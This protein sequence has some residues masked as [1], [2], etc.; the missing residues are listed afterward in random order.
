M[1]TCYILPLSHSIFVTRCFLLA[2]GG[3]LYGRIHYRSGGSITTGPRTSVPGGGDYRTVLVLSPVIRNLVA[4]GPLGY[5]PG[6]HSSLDP[7]LHHEGALDQQTLR[8]H[9]HLPRDYDPASRTRW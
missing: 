2:K 1:K 7:A 8:L 3:Q 9:G 4:L 6:N 5:C